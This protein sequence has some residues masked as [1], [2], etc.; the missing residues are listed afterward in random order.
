M[1]DHDDDF[2]LVRGSGNVFADFDVENQ[3]L[4]NLCTVSIFRKCRNMNENIWLSS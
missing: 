1:A 3:S 4:T 2:E